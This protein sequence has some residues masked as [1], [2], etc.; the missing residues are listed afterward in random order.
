MQGISPDMLSAQI[1]SLFADIPPAAIKTGMLY[2]AEN[3]E[4]VV[5]AL[6]ANCTRERCPPSKPRVA[7][8]NAEDIHQNMLKCIRTPTNLFQSLLTL[9]WFLHLVIHY[10]K[11]KLYLHYRPDFYLWPPLSRRIPLKPKYWEAWKEDLSRP[12]KI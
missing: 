2:S 10:Y 12:S 9:S 6:E 1:N 5:K 4:A 7:T 11:M 3:I 8:A